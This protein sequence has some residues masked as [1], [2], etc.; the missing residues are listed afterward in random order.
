MKLYRTP[1]GHW[2]G[3]KDEAIVIAKAHD[4]TYEQYDVPYD[5]AGL[6]AFLNGYKVGAVPTSSGPTDDTDFVVVRSPVFVKPSEVTRSHS[7]KIWDRME[8]EDAILAAPLDTAVA[9][10][11]LVMCRIRDFTKGK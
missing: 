11:E 2:A 1:T 7:Q 5:K 4:T 3:T 10:A 6:L 9:L 8:L